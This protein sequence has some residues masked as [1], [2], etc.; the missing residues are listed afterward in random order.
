MLWGL[1]IGLALGVAGF[2]CGAYVL[3]VEDDDASIPFLF[4]IVLAL[5]SVCVV[6][7]FTIGLVSIPV[8]RHGCAVFSRQT[9][10]ETRFVVWNGGLSS[11]C[12]ARTSDGRWLPKSQLR[13]VAP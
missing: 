2:A 10:R 12:L 11:E 8:D 6:I 5:L 3:Y 1:W 7:G 13:D 9:G 4:G